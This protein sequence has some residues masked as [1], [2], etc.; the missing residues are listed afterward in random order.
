MEPRANDASQPRLPQELLFLIIESLAPSSPD[1]ILPLYHENAKCLLALTRV[2]RSVSQLAS[3]LLWKSCPHITSLNQARAYGAALKCLSPDDPRRPTSLF[4]GLYQGT[5]SVPT[6]NWPW[7][8]HL[9]EPAPHAGYLTGSDALDLESSG[10]TI[11]G[12]VQDILLSVGPTLQRLIINMPLGAVSSAHDGDALIPL[13]RPAFEALVHLEEF[14]SVGDSFRFRTDADHSEVWAMWPKL[15]RLSL[16]S[17]TMNFNQMTSL[18]HLQTVVISRPSSFQL[19]MTGNVK[20]NLVR[21]L[22]SQRGDEVNSQS[23]QPFTLVLVDAFGAS[24]TDLR[25][26]NLACVLLVDVGKDLPHSL[27]QFDLEREQVHLPRRWI[28]HHALKGTLWATASAG[29]S[30]W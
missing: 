9:G 29:A 3:K 11:G 23:Q 15:R 13:L 1:T 4:L 16:D 2:C 28:Q 6:E 22:K 30:R 18:P 7:L 27:N 19:L 24:W 20:G 25:P 8:R 10:S 14:T 17:P 21:E 12:L 26:N 5:E